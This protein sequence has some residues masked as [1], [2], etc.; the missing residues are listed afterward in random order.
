MNGVIDGEGYRRNELSDTQVG[1]VEISS[2]S[3]REDEKAWGVCYGVRVPTVAES[4]L[5]VRV[6]AVGFTAITKGPARCFVHSRVS[7]F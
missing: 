3:S 2:L 7:Q 1:G 6:S 5:S 4:A